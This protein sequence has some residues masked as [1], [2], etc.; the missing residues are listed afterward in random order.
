MKKNKILYIDPPWRDKNLSLRTPSRRIENH[1]PTMCL[2]DI[3][4]YD[5]PEVDNGFLFL[6]STAPKL[7][8]AIEVMKAWGFD[9]RTCMI[10]DKEIIGTG[11]YCRNQH[12]L[13]LIGRKGKVKCPDPHILVSSVY[14]ER[15]REHSRK[16]S[17]F[18]NMID[19]YYP[20]AEK[21]ELFA[22]EK[23][24]GWEIETN[25]NIPSINDWI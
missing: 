6:W 22:R 21:I 20:D 9:Y 7:P 3:K 19:K 4:N 24:V 17:Y 8:E 15:R 1:Y 23:P 18:R 14:R 25:E 13:L 10:W 5:I 11:F 12:E 2:E 16:P